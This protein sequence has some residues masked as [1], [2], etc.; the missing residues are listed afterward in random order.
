MS[1]EIGRSA[2]LSRDLGPLPVRKIL[3]SRVL[4]SLPVFNF[5]PCWLLVVFFFIV[6][7]RSDNFGFGFYNTQSKC[8]LTILSAILS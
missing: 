4:D 2:T 8:V 7:G 1:P 6:T 5:S 3:V